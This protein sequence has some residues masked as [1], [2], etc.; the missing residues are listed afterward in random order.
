MRTFEFKCPNCGLTFQY[1]AGSFVDHKCPPKMSEAPAYPDDNPKTGEGLKKPPMH[2]IPST[3]LVHM[4][5]VMALGAKKYGAYNWRERTVSVSIYVAAAERHLRS[6]F[7]GE[8]VDPESGASHLAHVMACCAI[9]LDAQAIEKL[10]DDRPKPA[11][12]AQLIRDY[13]AKV[14]TK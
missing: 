14:G 9:V 3:A 1:P 13:A 10:N 8:S 6:F 2:L 12:T 7:D 11:P 5:Q 4:A